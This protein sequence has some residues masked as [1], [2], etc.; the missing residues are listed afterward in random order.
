MF[1]L[2]YAMTLLF[3]SLNHV[4]GLRNVRMVARMSRDA[5]FG[6]AGAKTSAQNIFNR[7]PNG[8]PN[9]SPTRS[10][11]SSSALSVP[12]DK[13]PF[14]WCQGDWAGWCNKFDASTGEVRVP[15]INDA[16]MLSLSNCHHL[17]SS[18]DTIIHWNQF[19]LRSVCP[20]QT[21][22]CRTR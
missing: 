18:F 8:S 9:R 11:L 6:G 17:I 13:L 1:R 19:A 14:L 4:G 20:Y 7:S 22:Y 15:M 12:D 16:R 2:I 3:L 21:I 10:T 5:L